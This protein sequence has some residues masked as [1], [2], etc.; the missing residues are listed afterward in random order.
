MREH[1]DMSVYPKDSKLYSPENKKVI[2]KFSD[3]KPGHIIKEVISLKPKMYSIMAEALP[4]LD[5]K[6]EPK[7][8][9]VV[10]KGISKAAQK[11]LTHEEY[12]KILDTKGTNTCNV[13]S[14][15]S[16]KRKLYTITVNKRGL[17]SPNRKSRH[18][19]S[20]AAS[21]NLPYFCSYYAL[22]MLFSN[23]KW[24]AIIL[25]FNIV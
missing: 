1:M 13:K 7:E 16:F 4:G 20:S 12:R 10:A 25:H 8:H 17:S 21:P 11:K 2:G 14:I 18:L 24:S 15:R 23:I 3:E 6:E 19:A 9:F 5:E 22:N